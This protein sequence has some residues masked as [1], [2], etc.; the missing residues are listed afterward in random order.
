MSSSCFHI[1]SA[2]AASFGSIPAKG[3]APLVPLPPLCIA[4]RTPFLSTLPAMQESRFPPFR[5]CRAQLNTGHSRGRDCCHREVELRAKPS[6]RGRKI[7]VRVASVRRDTALC[8]AVQERARPAEPFGPDVGIAA[9]PRWTLRTS[10]ARRA[11][12][13][14]PS[15]PAHEIGRPP[16][17]RR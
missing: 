16:T 17:R 13:R 10:L 5:A 15:R 8:V 12:R 3:P 4:M 9:C 1:F 14:A 6:N 2:S 7:Q 11:R